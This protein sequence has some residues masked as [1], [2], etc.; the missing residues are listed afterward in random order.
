MKIKK[1]LLISF[2][3]LPLIVS[4]ITLIF[5]PEV[6]P[7]HYGSDF[8]VDRYGSKFEILIFPVLILVSSLI[9]LLSGFFMKNEANKKITLNIGLAFI[10]FF[11]ALSYYIL[12]LQANNVT[13]ISSGVFGIERILLL[14]FGV[15]FI[16]IGNLLP[17]S[18]RNS[19]VGMR[20]KWSMTN[21]TVWKKSQLFS[22]ISMILLGTVFL[23]L[24]FVFPNIFLMF[25]LI[26][27]VI[28]TDTVYTYAAA[29]KYGDKS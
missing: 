29:K 1:I 12:Y 4:L 13:D 17:M 3:V 25:V 28:I 6:I 16:F 19:F 10:L 21:D 24:A 5:L 26:F 14:I 23:I 11:N 2:A 22:G 15:F 27:T 7:A 20:T 18:H 9:F 8:T